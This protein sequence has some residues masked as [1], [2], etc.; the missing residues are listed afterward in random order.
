MV[1]CYVR[2]VAVMVCYTAR[3]RDQAETDSYTDE[4]GFNDNV[5]KWLQ[6]LKCFVFSKTTVKLQLYLLMEGEPNTN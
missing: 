1:N 6:L 2:N 3:H 5:R 4:I